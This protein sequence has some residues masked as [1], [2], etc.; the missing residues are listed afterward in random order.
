MFLLFQKS[1]GTPILFQ[2]VLV[3]LGL[4]V[5]SADPYGYPPSYGYKPSYSQ[6]EAVYDTYD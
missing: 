5:V 4:A 3:A 1:Y 6:P 2:I